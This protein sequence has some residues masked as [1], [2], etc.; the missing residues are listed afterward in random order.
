MQHAIILSPTIHT[1]S[2]RTKV[3]WW[4]VSDRINLENVISKVE[5]NIKQNFNIF[6]EASS[7]VCTHLYECGEENAKKIK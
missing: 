3:K 4:C 5:E 6:L 1:E 7:S 2:L